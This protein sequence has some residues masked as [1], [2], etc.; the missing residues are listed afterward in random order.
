MSEPRTTSRAASGNFRSVVQ[1]SQAG[2]GG[3]TPLRFER[4]RDASARWE[5]RLAL[6]LLLVDSE[7]AYRRD[8]IEDLGSD[9]SVSA[10]R[11]REDALLAFAGFS[12]GSRDPCL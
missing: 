9:L 4:P 11:R 7:E 2:D 12:L 10:F 1:L 6:R 3:Q 5:R 8:L